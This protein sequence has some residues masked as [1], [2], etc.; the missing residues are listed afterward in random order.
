[1]GGAGPSH[2][3]GSLAAVRLERGELKEAAKLIRASQLPRQQRREQA[4]QV[5]GPGLEG[6]RGE[7]LSKHGQVQALSMGN[8]DRWREQWV[9]VYGCSCWPKL[10]VQWLWQLVHS[11]IPVVA[12]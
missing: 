8:G 7:E 3:K 1:M 2:G 10:C 11:A 6:S 12:V 5:R 4:I 9:M